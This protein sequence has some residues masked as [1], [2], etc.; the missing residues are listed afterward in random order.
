[1]GLSGRV[2][3]YGGVERYE[4][5]LSILRYSSS[6]PHKGM[7]KIMKRLSYDIRLPDDISNVIPPC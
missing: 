5:V 2:I 3:L 1:M 4:A 6:I 7:R